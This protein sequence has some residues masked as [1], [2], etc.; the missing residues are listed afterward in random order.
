MAAKDVLVVDDESLVRELLDGLLRHC[1]LRAHLAS[2]GTEAL[3]RFDK[4]RFDLVITDLHMPG[5]SGAELAAA[6]KGRQPGTPVILITGDHRV[7]TKLPV[8]HVLKKPFSLRQLR[9]ALSSLL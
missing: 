4:N 9:A 7:S 5:M 6:I 8:D 1:G 3:E 2:N